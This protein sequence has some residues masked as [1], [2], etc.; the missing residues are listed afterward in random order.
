MP[1]EVEKPV[2]ES[3]FTLS[4]PS[5]F[6]AVSTKSLLVAPDIET[7]VSC[8]TLAAYSAGKL[9]AKAHYKDVSEMRN[10]KFE[11]YN[12]LP[13]TIYALVNMGDM[14]DS[15]P[16]M[17]SAMTELEYRIPSYTGSSTS[18]ESLGL[19]M[20]GKLDYKP[21][22][23]PSSSIG[24]K[25]L[26]AKVEAHL[27]C[28]W[29]GAKIE[30]VKVFNLNGR[31]SPFGDSVAEG[32]SDIMPVQEFCAGTLDKEGTFTFYVPENRQGVA[33]GT[34]ASSSERRPDG[35]NSWISGHSDVLTYLEAS[36]S[37][38]KE[39]QGHKL[40]RS[41]LGGDAQADFDIIRNKRYLWDIR[42]G[43]DGLSVDDWKHEGSMSRVIRS[44]RYYIAPESFCRTFVGREVQLSLVYESSTTFNGVVTSV[45]TVPVSQGVRFVSSDGNC[46][47]S[48][49][50]GLVK[51]ISKGSVLVK[52][53]LMEGGTEKEVASRMV[54]VDEWDDD[55]DDDVVNL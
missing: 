37:G 33:T 11:L 29:D 43:E 50:T 19:P 6:E 32:S 1:M 51:G 8:V 39:W 22:V 7:R 35:S 25:R 48:S 16:T 2:S 14:S 24:V 34:V 15:I 54:A 4:L 41:Y 9:R 12:G 52:A 20:A 26:V 36:V 17:E 40:Y 31:L 18:L 44:S 46:L 55:W 49:A 13:Y 42:Y 5:P 28:S 10:M 27:Q 21:N 3:S 45:E 30:S 23:S 47:S 53:F 38:E